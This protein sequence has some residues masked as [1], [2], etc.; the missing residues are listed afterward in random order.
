[1][2]KAI[3]LPILLKL[4]EI[5]H[6]EK[7]VSYVVG[8]F[9]RDF[10]LKRP[11]KDIDIVC[12]GNGNGIRLA[13]LLAKSYGKE[14]SLSVFKNFGT[15]MVKTA[16]WEIEFVGARKESYQRNSRKPIVEEGSLK[17]DQ[18]R[19]D[20][21]INAMAISLNRDSYGE[22]IDPF[23]GIDDIQKRVTRT[24]LNPTIT[25]SDD[26]LRMM[27]AIRFATQLDFTIEEKAKDA[28][29]QNIHRLSIVSAER[30]AV[31]LNK[32]MLSN[33]AHKGIYLL[34]EMNILANLLPELV[35]LKG[36]ETIDGKGHK[37]NFVHSIQV[38][39]NLIMRSINLSN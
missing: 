10:I 26:P 6:Q 4:A 1:M 27:R 23:K 25:F 24:P 30:I 3:D 7:I 38:L 13:N 19:R 35:A 18:D 16:E 2:K 12:I 39:E 14:A 34:D 5:A 31:E 21:T 37:D 22:F 29:K 20:F 15:A 11:S 17:E 32:I 28:I 9:V 8:G 36:V 33:Q